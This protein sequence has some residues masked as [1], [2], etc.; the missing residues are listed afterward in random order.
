MIVVAPN[1]RAN[2]NSQMFSIG[3]FAHKMIVIAPNWRCKG[4]RT[5]REDRQGAQGRN[6]LRAAGVPSTP[7]VG[8]VRF[9]VRLAPSPW[10][11]SHGRCASSKRMRK[12]RPIGRPCMHPAPI[13]RVDH[14]LLDRGRLSPRSANGRTCIK[15]DA[16][17]RSE[18]QLYLRLRG[19]LLLQPNQK[20]PWL[21]CPTDWPTSRSSRRRASRASP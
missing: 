4:S 18:R 20:P 17:S 14:F 6:R 15:P 13:F 12:G 11:Q 2:Y 9:H 5:G 10:C 3:V 7:S 19:R 1:W 8:R 16:R 21:V